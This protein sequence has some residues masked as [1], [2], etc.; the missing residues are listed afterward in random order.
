[1]LRVSEWVRRREGWQGYLEF[2]FGASGQG[3][4]QEGA[5]EGKKKKKPV[6][7]ICIGICLFIRHIQMSYYVMHTTKM[8]KYRCFKMDFHMQKT[9][10]VIFFP[11]ASCS[12]EPW[13]F[14]ARRAEHR[15]RT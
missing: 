11:W 14:C 6:T 15:L 1:M 8:Y 9:I 5:Y 4:V 7:N 13:G 12:D 2:V 3:S 10:P